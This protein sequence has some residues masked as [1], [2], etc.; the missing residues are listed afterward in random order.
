MTE[1]TRSGKETEPARARILQAVA[2]LF[3]GEGYKATSVR[4]ICEAARVNVA[5]V[6]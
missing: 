4:R 6:N 1:E 3:A 5:M 2:D